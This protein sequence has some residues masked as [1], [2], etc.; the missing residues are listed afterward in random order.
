MSRPTA[1]EL[2]VYYILFSGR[3][4]FNQVGRAT[5]IA[6]LCTSSRQLLH[7]GR[8]PRR[9]IGSIAPILRI[10]RS[11]TQSHCQRPQ[12]SS[13]SHCKTNRNAI[14]ASSMSPP[15]NYR[16]LTYKFQKVLMVA[17]ADCHRP[18]RKNR[19]VALHSGC[20]CGEPD[21]RLTS[22]QARLQTSASAAA[23]NGAGG[24]RPRGDDLCQKRTLRRT[25][26]NCFF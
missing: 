10:I 12:S 9:L 3:A 11:V 21:V 1:G 5:V 24:G 13:A 19:H 6:R 18:L 15:L 16:P 17:S 8:D 4:G 20:W 14:T 22:R 7:V 23:P 26:A 2:I 25:R